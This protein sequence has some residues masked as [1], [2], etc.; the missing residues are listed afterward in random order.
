MGQNIKQIYVTLEILDNEIKILVAEY[1]NT[2]FNILKLVRNKTNA[3]NKFEIV[4]KE[5][6]K[7]DITNTI[8]EC[9]NKLGTKIEKIILIIPAYNFKRFP[10]KKVII[11]QKGILT[12]NDI[13]KALSESLNEEV[14]DDVIA[15]NAMANKYTI[16]GI[17]TRRLPEKELCEEASVDIDLLCAD[18]NLVIDYVTILEEIGIEVI[19]IVLNTYAVS[20][21]ASLFEESLKQ[22]VL[23]LDI[24]NNY[25]FLSLINKGKL[26]STEIINECISKIALYLRSTY[27]IPDDDI[28]KLIKYDINYDASNLDD[29]I[30][31]Y[32]EANNT[33]T[34]TINDLNN[35]CKDAIDGIADKIYS[36]SKDIIEEGVNIFITGEGEK[37]NALVNEIENRTNCEINRYY[38]E[39][40]GVRDPSLTSIYGALFAYHDKVMLYNLNVNCIDLLE[41]DA[42]ID[43]KQLDSEGETLTTKIKNLFKQ[44][45]EKEK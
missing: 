2:R 41:Y 34:I 3:L 40:I 43:Q 11:P 18:K 38:P 13:A 10:I 8:D 21:E 7:N 27:E 4:D 26:I 33:K 30:Y 23:L 6:L 19:D 17:S 15:V 45:I 25:S 39:I 16:N 24:Q 29:V 37:I 31:A 28:N 14:D 35:V 42:L 1:Y 22:N 9:A 36:L 32:N 44:Y 5:L 12:K 20:K